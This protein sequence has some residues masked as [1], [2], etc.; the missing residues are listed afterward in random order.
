MHFRIFIPTDKPFPEAS[1]TPLVDVGLAHCAHNFAA[2]WTDIEGVRGMYY[3]WQRP[4]DMTMSPKGLTWS[5]AKEFRGLKAGRYRIGWNAD[6]M[7]TPRELA[8]PMQVDGEPLWLGTQAMVWRLPDV[9]N[10]PTKLV[11]C[12]DTAKHE[13]LC[14]YHERNLDC[15]T[16]IDE[17]ESFLEQL[18]AGR[19]DPTANLVEWTRLWQFAFDTL[20][21]NYRVTP[22]IVDT[23]DLFTTDRIT[24]VLLSAI[25]GYQVARRESEGID[26]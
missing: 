2:E 1:T 13:R 16:W 19:T 5:D 22:E 8:V 4:G 10:L 23:L 24:K 6:A 26:G 20:A 11:L 3:H 25:G 9:M 18:K 21:I 14:R 12:G 15:R 17:C 7:P